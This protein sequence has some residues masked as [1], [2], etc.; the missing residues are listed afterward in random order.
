M[1]NF[2]KKDDIIQ[3]LFLKENDRSARRKYS[4]RIRNFALMLICFS[5]K[6][7]SYVRSEFSVYLVQKLLVNGIAQ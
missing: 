2:G 1:K 3:G 6:A 7:Y 5:A 4:E